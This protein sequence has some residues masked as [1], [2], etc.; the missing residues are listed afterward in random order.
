[1]V[2]VTYVK[3]TYIHTH[4][5]A[6]YICVRSNYLPQTVKWEK[7]RYRE[8]ETLIKDALHVKIV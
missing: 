2:K 3:N 5:Y 8:K 6:V 1:M 7:P 4:L